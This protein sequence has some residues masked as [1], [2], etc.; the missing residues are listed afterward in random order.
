VRALAVLAAALTSA[1]ATASASAATIDRL[2]VSREGTRF[3]MTLRARLD[4]PLARSHTVFRDFSLLPQINDAV[5]QVRLLDDA[6]EGAQRLYTRVRV[7]VALFCTRL[8][9]VQDLR[10]R[11]DAQGRAFD[12]VVLPGRSNLRYG[13]AQWRM[14]DCD[15]GTCLEFRAELEPDFWVPPLIGPWL[16]ERA[17][18]REAIATALGIERLAREPAAP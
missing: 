1:T 9:Q 16:I 10:E 8:D 11:S 15:G 17:M 12:A 14:R 13:R 6:P 4:A 18:R 7:C 5:E 2:E 3:G